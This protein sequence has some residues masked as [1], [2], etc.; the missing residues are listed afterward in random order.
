MTRVR[1][2]A[3]A[4]PLDQSGLEALAETLAVETRRERRADRRQAP[5]AVAAELAAA[6]RGPPL[7]PRQA[8]V[9]REEDLRPPT[10]PRE[11]TPPRSAPRSRPSTAPPEED[12]L[13]REAR[14]RDLLA[15][16]RARF[17]HLEDSGSRYVL[18]PASRL[19]H[20]LHWAT[21]ACA[22]YTVV[23]EPYLLALQ[24]YVADWRDT[25]PGLVVFLSVASELFLLLD[26]FGGA[27][28]G[29]FWLAPGG[30]GWKKE[31]H[32][33]RT[34]AHYART[35]L[36]IDLL[37]RVCPVQLAVWASNHRFQ[38]VDGLFVFSV[39]KLLMVARVYDGLSSLV[40]RD[41]SFYRLVGLAK[42]AVTAATAVHWFACAWLIVLARSTFGSEHAAEAAAGVFPDS[43]HS[44]AALVVNNTVTAQ[45]FCSY[46]RAVQKVTTVAYGDMPATGFA[47]RAF[48]MGCMFLG[49]ALLY[50]SFVNTLGAAANSD[51][52]D[53]IHQRNSVVDFMKYRSLA[54]EIVQD[55]QSFYQHRW[56]L[57]R[58]LV[59]LEKLRQI[60][61]QMRVH[62]FHCI[63]PDL[64]ES[65]SFFGT[66]PAEDVF[67]WNYLIERMQYATYMPGDRLRRADDPPHYDAIFIMLHGTVEEVHEETGYVYRRHRGLSWFGEVQEITGCKRGA[68][69]RA[70]DICDVL[71]LE[72]PVLKGLLNLPTFRDVKNLLQAAALQRINRPGIARWRHYYLK[73][74]KSILK[75]A[76][77]MPRPPAPW[78]R[79][80]DWD[81]EFG[82]A[83]GDKSSSAGSGASQHGKALRAAWAGGDGEVEGEDSFLKEMRAHSPVPPTQD[84][85][86]GDSPAPHRRASS[87]SKEMAQETR[88]GERV[89][90]AG[91][92]VHLPN[93]PQEERRRERGGEGG[94]TV[95]PPHGGGMSRNS[96]DSSRKSRPPALGVA[97]ISQAGS[98][99]RALAQGALD[100]G[101]GQLR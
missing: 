17:D 46:Y 83:T 23:A 79:T 45:Y 97:S 19:G 3:L 22:A 52:L 9:V 6:L 50:L 41:L 4:R 67:F 51:E 7:D 93:V 62:A 76:K 33:E 12:P 16:W 24:H 77:K 15:R 47:D 49:S 37:S 13:A 74:K 2:A 44:R 21:F 65:I 5:A 56:T 99:E 61:P 84:K 69:I 66:R 92:D 28:K 34:A 71:E 100:A 1:M 59:D 82:I 88:A 96:S 73:N 36:G 43:C 101:W 80:I 32:L 30:M 60:P 95:P 55:T 87:A 39:L 94:Q 64:R 11:P 42:A 35:W 68:E 75:M 14:R 27:F 8:G 31:M 38:S 89:G 57:S 85:G 54:V 72:M 63:Y 29:Y 53:Y 70:A 58:G 10:P 86:L 48:T 20:A 18:D 98:S 81:Q 90:D 91:S 78:P 25:A 40:N 26:L